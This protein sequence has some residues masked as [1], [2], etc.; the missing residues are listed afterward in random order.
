MGGSR[1]REDVRGAVSHGPY[2]GDGIDTQ[3]AVGKKCLGDS[4]NTRGC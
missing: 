3:A 2:V 1:V 4:V